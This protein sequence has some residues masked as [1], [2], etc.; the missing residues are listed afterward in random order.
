M[1]LLE[2]NVAA[3]NLSSEESE[4]PKKEGVDAIVC[5][6]NTDNLHQKLLYIQ[7]IPAASAAAVYGTNV[8][9]LLPFLEE[10]VLNEDEPEEVKLEV[11][12][13]LPALGR[14]MHEQQQRPASDTAA[15][16]VEGFQSDLLRLIKLALR[17]LEDEE[18]RVVQAAQTAVIEI[19]PWLTSSVITAELL[20]D[21]DR[22]MNCPEHEIRSAVVQLYAH[23]GP[24][25]Q[26]L[27]GAQTIILQALLPRI[28]E[29]SEDMDF[30]VRREVAIGLAVLG[31][32][33][34]ANTKQD[35]LLDAY[36]ALCSDRVWAVRKAC[37]E[38]LPEIARLAPAEMRQTKLLS[39]FDQFCED[40]SH[41]VQNSA[42]QQLGP[43]VT[44]L[45]KFNSSQSLLQRVAAIPQLEVTG[46]EAAQLRLATAFNFPAVL[47]FAGT[48]QWPQLQPAHAALMRDR[49]PAVRRTLAC[50][51]HEVAALLGPDQA[52]QDLGAAVQDVCRDTQEDV[53]E[54]LVHFFPA[55][56][57]QLP[58]TS[59][60][61]FFQTLIQSLS[62]DC[63]RWRCR[64]GLA[65]QLGALAKLQGL[66]GDIL[67]I[68]ILLCKDPTAAV[69]SAVA[70]Q[71]GLVVF[72]LWSGQNDKQSA[73]STSSDTTLAQDQA[74]E[75]ANDI[76]NLSVQN[77]SRPE[78]QNGS[79]DVLT[80]VQ[81]DLVRAVQT[82][83]AE[84]EHQTRQQY[85]EVCFHVANAVNDVPSDVFQSNFLQPM[86]SLV[87]D[88]VANVRLALARALASLS[89]DV[90]AE[91]PEVTGALD[92][93]ARDEDVDVA[94][95]VK[96]HQR[97]CNE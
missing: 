86:L 32:A 26:A 78:Q 82:L 85:I 81:S 18:E 28:L 8:E 44:T 74:T 7:C 20:P 91:L 54:G 65:E 58:S 9:T 94:A 2:P 75:L 50:S 45:E 49:D 23:L 57:A 80:D 46:D 71:M 48:E 15:E 60:S 37:A 13:Q 40:V 43:F 77:Q 6:A 76:S 63:A 55:L 51:L 70:K 21:L 14:V 16:S 72:Q 38:I 53:Q 4:L 36:V 68:A 11:A 56:L 84:N 17:L 61:S 12:V 66:Q 52:L 29:Q 33:M 27:D 62:L 19:A 88:K 92:C 87:H 67:P 95:Y 39:V 25:I 35:V 5:Y 34:P 96:N 24:T 97:V 69:R 47:A 73:S 3:V 31:T 83:A 42:L 89:K 41:W 93:L 30:Q 90:L 64:I 22:L 79:T 1:A 10:L 59:R